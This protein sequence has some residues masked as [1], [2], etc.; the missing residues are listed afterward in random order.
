MPAAQRS[1]RARVRLSLLE[2]LKFHEACDGGRLILQ[3]YDLACLRERQTALNSARVKR[4][5]AQNFS[6]RRILRVREGSLR[7]KA[8]SPAEREQARRS[9]FAAPCQARGEFVH[10]RTQLRQPS[11]F[12][13]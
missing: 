2:Y 13:V 10:A 11:P 6:Q 9:V 8:G 1:A 5:L 4:E 7:K 3:E 12:S